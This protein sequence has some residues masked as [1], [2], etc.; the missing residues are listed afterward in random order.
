MDRRS[1]DR[2]RNAE[3]PHAVR[4]Y[5]RNEVDTFLRELVDWLATGGADDAGSEAVRAEIERIGERT[6]G[7]LT[8]AHDAAEA[9]RADA[10]RDARQKLIDANVTVESLRTSADEYSEQ[11]REEADAYA[12][13]VRADADAYSEQSRSES[14]AAATE[15]RAAAEREAEQIVADAN[16]RRDEVEKQI[17]DLEGRRDG[18]LAELERLASGITGA[19][20]QHRGT[21]ES[22]E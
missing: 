4:G 6:T 7:V 13:K 20:T 11:T 1:L 3:F 8:E 19:A 18:V 2:I 10:N 17:A 22:A 15:S 12:R 9:I 16:R 14:D 5:D 21:D